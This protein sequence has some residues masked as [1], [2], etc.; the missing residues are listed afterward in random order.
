[1]MDQNRVNP[2]MLVLA[3]EAQELTQGGLADLIHVSQAK[4]SKYENNLLD[5]SESDLQKI[6]R[7]LRF[8]RDFF[9][10]QDKIYGLGS[11]SLFHRQRQSVPMS[12]QKRVQARV[13]ILRMQV[14][15]LL[16]SFD[17][18]SDHV[19]PQMDVDAHGR[20]VGHIARM[21]RASWHLPIGPVGNLTA[22]VE[23]AGGLV[24]LCDFGTPKIDAT[25]LWVPGMPPLFVMNSRAP[26][27]R[28]RFTLSHEIA[29][30]V[31]HR[32]P[33]SEI[34]AE[35]DQF[36]SEFLM[37]EHEVQAQFSNMT[38][39]KA[40]MLKPYWKVSIAAIVRRAFDVGCITER[41]Y[42]SLFTKLGANG[43]RT[44][45]PLPLPPER[46][47]VVTKLVSMHKTAFGYTDS[48]LRQLLFSDDPQFLNADDL[49]MPSPVRG[50][51]DPIPLFV[52]R[53]DQ[54]SRMNVS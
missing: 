15:R 13:N 32:F 41:Q 43:Y 30:A 23:G 31:M 19:F 34:E 12:I 54:Q 40:A 49:P 46:P 44:S 5:V 35:A 26:A 11:S 8:T 47:T 48:E 45:E 18:G 51:D 25:H 14:E 33:D 22:T 52:A 16:R 6:A 1:M 2:E 21:V 39:Q 37:P 36:A 20:D 27:D 7:A 24:L 53:N 28:Y 9:Y 38:L 10:Q 50:P 29:H 4:I 3:R 17:F 42:R